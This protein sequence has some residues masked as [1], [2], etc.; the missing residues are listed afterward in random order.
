MARM[1][2]LDLCPFSIAQRKLTSEFSLAYKLQHLFPLF[3][4][5]MPI[6]SVGHGSD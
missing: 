6:A 5:S 3:T 4:T 1:I 2:L